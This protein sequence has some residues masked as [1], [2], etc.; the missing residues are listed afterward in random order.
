MD[1]EWMREQLVS[2]DDIARRYERSRAPGDFIGDQALY[3]ELHRLEPTMKRILHRLD[4]QI[5]EKVNID[6]MAGEAMARN[7]I[8]RGLGILQDMDE[9]EKRLAP[10]APAL[11][12]DRLH[13]WVWDAART[14]W[15]SQHYRAA[16]HAAATSINA[17]TQAKV[18]RRDVAD[19]KL[20]QEAFSEKP[21]E[22]GKA[23]IRIPGVPH[24]PTVQSRQR[25]AMQLGLG[26]FFAIRNPAAHE[27]GEWPEQD[28][29]EQLAALSVL[30][31]LIDGSQ[32]ST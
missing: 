6:Q 5:A 23:R 31:R 12:A 25:G 4:P 2:F 19:D 32:V 7:E 24:D 29:L 11:L 30:A 15:E 26:C 9:W 27:T 18:N 3:D 16:V 13:P 28:A 22:L 17:H 14:F 21:P 10:D 8:Q 1:R 20:I